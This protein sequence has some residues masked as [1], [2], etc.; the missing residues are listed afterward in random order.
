MDDL[1]R[2]DPPATT[3]K[4]PQCDFEF[5][6]EEDSCPQCGSV[7]GEPDPDS[8]YDHMRDEVILSGG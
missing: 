4:C 2:I 6:E 3:V 7:R 1:N 5:D 8:V